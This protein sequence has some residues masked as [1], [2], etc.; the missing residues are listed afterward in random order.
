MCLYSAQ[1]EG[2]TS[3]S[4]LRI[5]YGSL[6][7]FRHFHDAVTCCMFLLSL[8]N[9]TVISLLFGQEITIRK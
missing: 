4:G 8:A 2:L 1:V 7:L 5:H 3:M 6:S 9:L